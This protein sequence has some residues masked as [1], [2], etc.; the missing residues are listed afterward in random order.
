MALRKSC[1]G[2]APSLDGIPFEFWKILHEHYINDIKNEKPAFDVVGALT[3]VYRDIQQFGVSS[4]TGFVDGWMCPIYKKNERD[5]IANYRPITCL[6]TDYKIHTKTITER[7]ATFITTVIHSDQ[8]GFMRGR[9]IHD[10][11]HLVQ[12]VIQLAELTGDNGLIIALDQEKA[13]DK[14]AHE[15]LWE[16]LKPFEFP[17][18]FINL[19]KSL[20]E[21][22][23]TVVM[24]NGEASSPFKVTREL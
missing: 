11:T 14:I 5:N 19:V 1:N 4:T 16:V 24:I 8:A 17:K 3:T 12:R 20:Y 18:A 10:Q 22:A 15:Y 6:N 2:Q 23:T 7:L 13:Y 21:H 9:S